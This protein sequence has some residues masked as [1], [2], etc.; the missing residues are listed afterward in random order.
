MTQ[1]WERQT[2]DYLNFPWL[3]KAYK[4][5]TSEGMFTTVCEKESKKP[6]LST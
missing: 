5:V 4:S 1:I 3:F 6:A 2:H